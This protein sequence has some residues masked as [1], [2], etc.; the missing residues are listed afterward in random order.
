MQEN[1]LAVTPEVTPPVLVEQPKQSNFLVILLSI[2]L[3]IS[4]VIAGFFAYQTQ[5]L[6]NELQGIRNEKLVD[7][8]S[9]VEPVATES[10]ELDP[11]ANWKTYTND[12]LGIAFKYPEKF[13]ILVTTP[14]D[15]ETV[16]IDNPENTN[17]SMEIS[18]S[19]K[20]YGYGGS[21]IFESQEIQ[22]NKLPIFI[23]SKIV[24][25]FSMSENE[26]TNFFVEINYKD[27]KN[28]LQIR[29]TYPFKVLPKSEEFV[30]FDQ[31]LSTFKLLE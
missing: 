25:R 31:I 7:L 18:R 8:E 2:L 24:K 21:A 12:V 19:K 4:V 20:I 15:W 1:N 30:I 14:N 9:A 13:D 6:F 10:S 23:N 17:L 16:R 11:T 22:L 28:P 3:L 26:K 27:D 5:K 29:I